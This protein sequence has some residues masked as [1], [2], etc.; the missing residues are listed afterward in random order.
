MHK[1]IACNTFGVKQNLQLD[2]QLCF[3]LYAAS[4]AVTSAY[5]DVLSELDL[6]YPQY[7]TLLALWEEDGVTISALGARLQLDSGT[8]SPLLKRL[9]GAGL[10]ERRRSSEDERR[11]T[12]HLTPSG[13]D[14]RE[15]ADQVQRR[16]LSSVDL[17]STE[18]DT[19]RTLAKRLCDSVAAEQTLQTRSPR[20]VADPNSH[21]DQQGAK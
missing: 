14:L 17:T 11:V 12:V 18:I 10:V 7:L 19:L 15:H 5:R 20:A 3:A 21:P 6:T 8:L 9:D 2:S 13:S 1:S 4:R 16:A